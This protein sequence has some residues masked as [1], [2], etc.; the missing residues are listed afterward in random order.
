MSRSKVSAKLQR[1]ARGATASSRRRV[2]L[3]P[4]RLTWAATWGQK[5]SSQLV[6]LVQVS[7]QGCGA[8]K[9]GGKGMAGEG[10]HGG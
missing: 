3:P 4:T 9:E 8:R 10:W 1:P 7:C 5:R 2:A 6:A